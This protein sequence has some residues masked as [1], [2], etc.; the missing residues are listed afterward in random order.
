MAAGVRRMDGAAVASGS[1]AGARLV[2]GRSYGLSGQG[3]RGCYP[4]QTVLHVK[5][6]DSALKA[7]EQYQRNKVSY[8][9]SLL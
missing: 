8:Q 5:L 2:E 3:T 7:L 4:Q 6:T 9:G 1:A